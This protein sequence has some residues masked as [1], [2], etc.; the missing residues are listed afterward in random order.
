MP[1]GP[2]LFVLAP[3]RTAEPDFLRHSLLVGLLFGGWFRFLAKFLQLGPSRLTSPQL[4]AS[5]GG[6]QSPSLLLLWPAFQRPYVGSTPICFP[7]PSCV[8]FPV[9]H[10][11]RR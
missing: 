7:R 5:R 9:P 3:S 11:P 10:T 4:P 6:P 1:V 2:A 8:L